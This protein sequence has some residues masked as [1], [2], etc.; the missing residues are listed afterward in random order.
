MKR[1]KILAV[2]TA[3]LVLFSVY[4]STA[5]AFGDGLS[6]L[7]E[8]FGLSGNNNANNGNSDDN[9]EDTTRGNSQVNLD[10]GL[11]S[12]LQGILGSAAD[13]LN[14]SQITDILNNFDINALLGGD[15]EVIN[16]VLDLIG[17]NQPSKSSSNDDDDDDSGNSGN[18]GS[19]SSTP[20]NTAPQYTNV[21]VT[22]APAVTYSYTPG[23]T[24]ANG[25]T[26][27][28]GETTTGIGETTTLYY[29][30]PSTIYAEQITTLPYDYQVDATEAAA[31]DGV[32]LKMIIGVSILLI[33]GVAVVGVA[34]SLKKSKV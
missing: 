3:A 17:A 1:V 15:S 14:S 10:S 2:I 8:Y 13:R 11:S 31:K 9:D 26:T 21:Y 16:E 33:S 5:F 12:M 28:P 20:S 23:T 29:V 25:A 4:F 32:T 27:L 34:L 24:A 22:E 6:A 18:K 30:A 19:Q 7:G